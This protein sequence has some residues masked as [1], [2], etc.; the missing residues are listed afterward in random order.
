MIK[1]SLLNFNCFVPIGYLGSNTCIHIYFCKTWISAHSQRGRG[2]RD[3]SLRKV[4]KKN[5]NMDEYFQEIKNIIT[6]V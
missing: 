4:K 6:L 2:W 3:N 5:E 1:S